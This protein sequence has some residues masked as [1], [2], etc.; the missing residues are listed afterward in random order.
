[1]RHKK[2]E[3][4]RGCNKDE[5]FEKLVKRKDEYA[6]RKEKEEII[7]PCH[8]ETSIYSETIHKNCINL[9]DGPIY[10]FIHGPIYNLFH[11]STATPKKKLHLFPHFTGPIYHFRV[12]S[13][14]SLQN[15][16]ER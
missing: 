12:T 1:M 15:L 9:L 5:Y 11:Y 8:I 16:V 7:R 14:R 4:L 3:E 6:K 2:S 13:S 10:H